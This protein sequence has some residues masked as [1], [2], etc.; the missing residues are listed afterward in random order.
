MKKQMNRHLEKRISQFNNKHRRKTWWHNIVVAMAILVVFVTTYSLILNAIAIEVSEDPDPNLFMINGAESSGEFFWEDIDAGLAVSATLHGNASYVGALPEEESPKLSVEFDDDEIQKWMEQYGDEDVSIPLL[1]FRIHLFVGDVELL[2]DNCKADIALTLKRDLFSNAIATISGDTFDEEAPCEVPIALVATDGDNELASAEMPEAD[3]P[4]L[5]FSV[6]AASLTG[7]VVESNPAYTLQHFLYFPSV[8]TDIS[9]AGETGTKIPIVNTSLGTP[10]GMSDVHGRDSLSLENATEAA[11]KSK[12]KIF[13]VFLTDDYKVKT[14]NELKRIFVDEETSYRLNPQ[15][16]YMSRLFN[17][18]EDYNSNYTMSEIWVY[19]PKAGET[20]PIDSLQR[21]DFEI[22]SVPLADD[23]VTHSPNQIRFTNNPANKHIDEIGATEDYPYYRT[24]LISNNSIVRLVYDYTTAGDGNEDGT[25]QGANFFDY[26]I[27]DGYVY[28]DKAGTVQQPTS[29]QTLNPNAVLYAKTAQQGINSADNY[30][31]SGRKLAF[32]NANTNMGLDTQ[33]INSYYINRWNSKVYQ[34]CFF[35]LVNGLTYDDDGIAIP[36]FIDDVTA[37]DLFSL[38]AQTGK[39]SYQRFVG[40]GEDKVL[41]QDY[42][43]GFF[44]QGGS[45]TLSYVKDNNTGDRVASNLRYLPNPHSDYKT[46]F[47]NEFWPLDGS[48]SHGTDGHDL[49]FG[50]IAYQ[51]NRAII[52]YTKKF[53]LTDA[54]TKDHN[55][56]FGMSYTVDFVIQP[57]YCSP[58]DY[59]FY[60]DDDMWVF[61]DKLDENGNIIPNETKLVA[62]IGGVHSSAGEYVNLWEYVEPIGLDEDR[63]ESYR[64]SVFYTER[65]ASGSTCYMRFTVPLSANTLESP[66]RDEALVFE[67][68]ELDEKGN[69]LP[70]D[71]NGKEYTF[72][73]T[74][75]NE[76]GASFEDIYDYNIYVREDTPD[77]S[78]ENAQAIET[79]VIGT[80]DPATGKYVFTLRNGEYIVITNLPN[81]TYYTIEEIR[82]PDDQ[83]VTQYQKGH[84]NHIDGKQVDT[85]ESAIRYD[86]IVGNPSMICVSGEDGYNYVCF[87]N[88]PVIKTEISPGDGKSVHIGQEIIYDI[89]WAN[90]TNRIA[91][92]VITDCLDEGVDFIGAKFVPLDGHEDI[93]RDWWDNSDGDYVSSDGNET[94]SYDKTTRAVVWTRKGQEREASGCVSLKV[95]VNELA[96]KEETT[97]GKFGTLTPRVEN[98]AQIDIGNRSLVTNI[99]ENPVWGPFKKEIKP[100]AQSPL[101]PGDEVEYVVTWKNYQSSTAVVKIRDPLDSA[102]TYLENS[103]KEY[104]GIHDTNDIAEFAG[105]VLNY[106]KETNTLSWDLGEQPPGAEGYVVFKVILNENAKVTRIENQAYVQVGN[107]YEIET[108]RIYNPI[109]SYKLPET[110]GIG[111]VAYVFIGLV[112]TVS[113][114]LAFWYLKRKKLY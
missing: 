11:L 104:Y 13:N 61:I 50:D 38:K 91:D 18:A 83:F 71:S 75:I 107:D 6:N 20:R 60:G 32:G 103:A 10:G 109:Y 49:K 25:E 63:S 4:I 69:Q 81:D 28:T 9:Y 90:D 43:L 23:G 93:D 111:T 7:V 64:L 95:K 48:P 41:Q 108:N 33:T 79:G 24:V 8:V 15:V 17:G 30:T 76:Q 58:L 73:L 29:Y 26:D 14:N 96:G 31:S 47:T 1:A 66:E 113:A 19:T 46:I 2:L 100:G 86:H 57:G 67:K 3:D 39:K 40:E 21:E 70:Y 52:N 45:Y 34:G 16:E 36:L 62:D 56:F 85:L 22:Y 44:R 87:T 72:N 92:V 88:A 68:T 55:A 12:G 53:P 89:E 42:S 84:H 59:W 114:V 94:I 74:L 80:A 97:E 78:A 112:M 5:T 110:G 77:H 35:G 51:N 98:Q 82:G 27:T 99:V 54:K 105:A 65:G 102:V 101:V 106:D 37:P